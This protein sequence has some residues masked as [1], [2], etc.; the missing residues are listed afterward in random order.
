MSSNVVG[1]KLLLRPIPSYCQLCHLETNFIGILV[2]LQIFSIY[3]IHQEWSSVKCRPFHIGL[4]ALTYLPLDKWRLFRIRHFQKHF[5]EWKVLNFGSFFLEGF[6]WGS[7]WQKVIVGS[8]KGLVPDRRQATIWAKDDIV[9]WRLY[10]LLGL[11][12]LISIQYL[13]WTF[14]LVNLAGKS[15]IIGL[16]NNFMRYI[17][18]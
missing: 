4:S 15:V 9:I 13:L 6:S 7:S 2:K 12:I 1:D 5:H 8:G 10:A 3:E 14:C 11:T 18:I 16:D 17:I